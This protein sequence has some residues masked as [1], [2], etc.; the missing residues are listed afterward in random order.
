MSPIVQGIVGAVLAL[1][2]W[3]LT[4]ASAGAWRLARPAAWAFDLVTPAV[5]F[6]AALAVTGRPVL[7]GL[8]VGAALGGIAFADTAK[9]RFLGEPVVF[10]DLGI[11]PKLVTRSELYIAFVGYGKVVGGA[12]AAAALVAADFAIEPALPFWSP[13]EGLAAVAG[14]AALVLAVAGPGVRW[15]AGPLRRFAVTG[16]PVRDSAALGLCG[17]QFVHG[18]VTRADRPARRARFEPPAAAPRAASALGARA[19]RGTGSPLLLFQLESF[20]DPRR[21]HPALAG[22]ALP[23]WDRL[24]AEAAVR[25]RLEVPGVGGNT[26]RTEFAVLSGRPPADLGLDRLHPYHAFCRAPVDTLAWRLKAQGYRTVCLHPYDRSFYGRDRAMPNLGFD[27]FLGEEAFRDAPRL[28]RYVTDL[29]VAE[30]AARIVEEDGPAVFVFAVTMGAHGPWADD[31]VH[32][33]PGL[34]DEAVR[35]LGDYL[36]RLTETD[37]AL[38]RLTAFLQARGD[39]VLGLYGDHLPSLPA[40]WGALGGAGDG[41][42]DHL[43]W[44]P[45][46][47]SASAATDLQAHELSAHLAAV[48]AACGHGGA[49]RPWHE[50]S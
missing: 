38:A 42:T 3:L 9:R 25:G 39:G 24:S 33:L 29:A 22:F 31:P 37:R 30:M 8:V 43:V 27:R 34:P 18:V 7:S 40:L 6:A 26:M 20:A 14:A 21:L 23:A 19:G 4:R 13:L 47:P 46:A 49:A 15:A 41:R 11:L 45:G 50:A 28:G 32:S 35:G 36:A 16:D 48:L 12:L 1:A 10:T 2:G 44:R 5:L 17:M